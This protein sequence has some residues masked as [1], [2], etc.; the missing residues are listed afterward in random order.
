MYLALLT[1]AQNYQSYITFVVRDDARTADL[2]YQQS[3]TTYQA[4]NNYPA[5][6]ATGKSLYDFNS[7]GATVASTGAKRAAKVS[8]DR[9]YA[10]GYGSGQFGGN[11]WNWE[12]YYIGWLEQNGYDVAYSTNLD[13]HS[14]GARLLNFKGFL[15][16]GH[17]EYWSK[18]MLDNVTAA[19]N[20]GVNLGFFGSNTAYWQVRFEQSAGGV[21]NR[22]MVCIRAPP[23]TR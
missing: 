16:V 15:S 21:A 18:A 12:R 9:P 23:E 5:D 20:A 10:D 3:V 17:D 22:V 8:F 13:T 14:S 6:G 1:N 19:R 11:S 2:L 4:Y 7:Y